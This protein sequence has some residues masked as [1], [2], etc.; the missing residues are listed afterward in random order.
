MNSALFVDKQTV[1]TKLSRTLLNIVPGYRSHG[2]SD[3][4]YAQYDVVLSLQSV[5]V[6]AA[7]GCVR[8]N[9]HCRLGQ[10]DASGTTAPGLVS[11]TRTQKPAAPGGGGGGV[12]GGGGPVTFIPSPAGIYTVCVLV[13]GYRQASSDNNRD[14]VRTATRTAS[15]T[16]R[17]KFKQWA[18]ARASVATARDGAGKRTLSTFRAP[19]NIRR[20]PWLPVCVCR[21]SVRASIASL[22][23]LFPPSVRLPGD[24]TRARARTHRTHTH[25]R[26]RTHAHHP[27]YCQNALAGGTVRP[28]RFYCLPRRFRVSR[29]FVRIISIRAATRDGRRRAGRLTSRERDA[30]DKPNPFTVVVFCARSTRQCR[31]MMMTLSAEDYRRVQNRRLSSTSCC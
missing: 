27:A 23:V 18:C 19:Y 21:V 20:I 22:S 4:V 15:P 3:F 1:S 29:G 26:S 24:S 28:C 2:D 7:A 12:G 31:E 17:P 13:H 30:A 5:S 25:K 16:R 14:L 11:H 9:R 10:W 6:E 8:C